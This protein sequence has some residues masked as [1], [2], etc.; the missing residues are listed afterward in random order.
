MFVIFRYFVYLFFFY[1]IY[2]ALKFFIVY[3][4]E[5]AQKNKKESYGGQ[6]TKLKIKSEDIIEAE[7]E[8]LKPEKKDNP[9]N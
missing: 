8:E 7:F 3:I 1:L 5:P 9:N 6:G 4:S 2:K